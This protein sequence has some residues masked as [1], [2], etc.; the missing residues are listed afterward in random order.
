MDTSPPP[1][2][3]LWPDAPS[4][5][6]FSHPIKQYDSPLVSFK[7]LRFSPLFL[8]YATQQGLISSTFNNNIDPS[9]QVCKRELE[10]QRSCTDAECQNQHCRPLSDAELIRNLLTS[11]IGLE[12][13]EMH[14]SEIKT[15]MRHIRHADKCSVINH[16]SQIISLASKIVGQSGVCSKTPSLFRRK[17]AEPAVSE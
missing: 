5:V 13:S 10:G 3:R 2:D 1:S 17:K 8:F 14:L 11:V 6:P 9:K 4:V 7:N 16:V 12:D 15:L